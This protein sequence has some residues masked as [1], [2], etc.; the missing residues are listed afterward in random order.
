[1]IWEQRTENQWVVSN[2]QVLSQHTVW[3][4]LFKCISCYIEFCSRFFCTVPFSHSS[5]AS[6]PWTEDTSDWLSRK[7]LQSWSLRDSDIHVLCGPRFTIYG[8]SEYMAKDST[9]CSHCAVDLRL[10]V[11]PVVAT[12]NYWLSYL[13]QLLNSSSFL[14]FIKEWRFWLR[15]NFQRG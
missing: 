4:F 6:Y 3:S 15:F 7:K 11:S 8:I 10:V 9:G 5:G 14:F 12:Q 13:G 1:M 2:C